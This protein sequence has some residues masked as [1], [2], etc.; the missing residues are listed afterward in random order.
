MGAFNCEVEFGLSAAAICRYRWVKLGKIA[1]QPARVPAEDC[2][3]VLA[4]LL[5]PIEFLLRD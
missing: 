4:I 2:Q 5:S 1:D 3:L